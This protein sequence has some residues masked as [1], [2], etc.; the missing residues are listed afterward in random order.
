MH[1]KVEKVALYT[2]LTLL[3]LVLSISV[4][5]HGQIKCTVFMTCFDSLSNLTVYPSYLQCFCTS[6]Y[7]T[8]VSTLKIQFSIDTICYFCSSHWWVLSLLCKCN[9]TVLN[10]NMRSQQ[11]KSLPSPQPPSKLDQ[12]QWDSVNSIDLKNLPWFKQLIG[13]VW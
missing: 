9:F 5:V 7:A 4:E 13:N 11:M 6:Y 1:T 3:W 2:T 10:T 12:S 8:Q